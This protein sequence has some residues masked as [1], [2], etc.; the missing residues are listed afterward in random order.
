MQRQD[1]ARRTKGVTRPVST[2]LQRP[3][4]PAD[5]TENPLHAA[6]PSG[7]LGS[8]RGV[9][10]THANPK[11]D[12][13]GGGGGLARTPQPLGITPSFVTFENPL[14][15]SIDGKKVAWIDE[16]GGL[17]EVDVEGVHAFQDDDAP[18]GDPGGAPERTPST[19]PTQSAISITGSAFGLLTGGI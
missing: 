4:Q 11:G 12:G 10:M 5:L 14:S 17:D 6:S 1:A 9:K 3:S 7:D 13:E 15:A 19:D 8:Q 18:E 2:E 16:E